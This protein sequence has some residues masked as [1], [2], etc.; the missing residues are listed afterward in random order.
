MIRFALVVCQI[1][2]VVKC[3]AIGFAASILALILLVWYLA[4]DQAARNA[5]IVVAGAELDDGRHL[6]GF[7]VK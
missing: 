4:G 7:R 6:T 2:K 1:L 3:N 5:I